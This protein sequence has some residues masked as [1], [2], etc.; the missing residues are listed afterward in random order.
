M[1]L[2]IY[3]F[4]TIF[5]QRFGTLKTM[6]TG[7]LRRP[8]PQIRHHYSYEFLNGLFRDSIVVSRRSAVPRTIMAKRTTIRT[9]PYVE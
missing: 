8:P 1:Y 7:T 4:I 3:T 2:Y 9:K 6:V 5:D